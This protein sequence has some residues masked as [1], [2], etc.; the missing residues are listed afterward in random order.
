MTKRKIELVGGPY[1]G[2]QLD[3]DIDASDISYRPS[4]DRPLQ[5]YVIDGHE[6]KTGITTFLWQNQTA[7][8]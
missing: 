6:T 1:C 2:V 8:V 3:L 4:M 7:V 5:R